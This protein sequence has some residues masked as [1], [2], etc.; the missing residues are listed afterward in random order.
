MMIR[1]TKLRFKGW[2]I[3]VR[4]DSLYAEEIGRLEEIA[5]DLRSDNWE[6]QA[7]AERAV[8][9]EIREGRMLTLD[10]LE[11]IVGCGVCYVNG[12]LYV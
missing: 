1:R 6:Q 5:G 8:A 10:G 7:V 4:E 9:A 3:F 11:R 2:P 12:T